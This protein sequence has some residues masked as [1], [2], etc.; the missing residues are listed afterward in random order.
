MPKSSFPQLFSSI[1]GSVEV[2]FSDDA[3]ISSIGIH[4]HNF[5]EFAYLAEGYGTEW[6]NDETYSMK[7]GYFSI[8]YP[9]QTHAV[10]L[11][12]KR[13]LKYYFTAISMDNFLGAGSVAVELKDLF[14]RMRPNTASRYY[15]EG[16]DAD[17]LRRAFTEMLAE[18]TTRNKWWELSV[19][20]RIL[21][22][23]I[24][25]DRRYGGGCQ[26]GRAPVNKSTQQTADILYYIYNNFKDDLSLGMLSEHFELSESYLSALIKS[27]LGL[28]FSDYLHNLRLMYACT[29]LVSTDMSVTDA[30]YA[31]GFQSYRNF[32]RFF[33]KQY[34]VSPMQF[35]QNN[36][37]Q[38]H[39]TLT[40]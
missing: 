34:G 12:A 16:A 40:E 37:G 8:I 22:V 39:M 4:S 9:W 10:Q 17:V 27:T 7:P 20:A 14:L 5:I 28:T 38:E 33:R 1:E 3:Y 6:I 19:K 29:L 11:D 26:P 21:D 36:K 30:S 15:F 31:S 23:L 25:F 24:L 35:R 32:V 2:R 13:P 18:Y